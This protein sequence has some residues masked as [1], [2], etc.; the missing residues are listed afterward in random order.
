MLDLRSEMET[1][2]KNQI[3][4]IQEKKDTAIEQLTTKHTQKYNDIKQYYQEITN[5]NFDIIKQL[6]DELSEAKKEDAEK[7]RQKMD[8]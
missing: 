8:Q 2:R 1:K 6:K 7:T 4:L 3:K 5:T